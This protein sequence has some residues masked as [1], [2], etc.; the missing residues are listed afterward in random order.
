MSFTYTNNPSERT[1]D[2]V[3]LELGDTLEE[4]HLIEDEEI[5][6]CLQQ[7]NDNV[8][9]AAA[10]G[11]ESI[12]ARFS[13]EETVRFSGSTVDKAD[14]QKRYRELARL[15]RRRATSSDQF[16]LNAKSAARHRKNATNANSTHGSFYRGMFS[17]PSGPPSG[18]TETLD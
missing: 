5:K 7:S 11:A 17:H 13:R 8:L 2:A 10:R 4:S 14:V 9:S 12:A 15:L 16:V 18:E 1:I 3:R 6:Y